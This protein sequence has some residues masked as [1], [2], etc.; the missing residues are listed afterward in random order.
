[1]L[2]KKSKQNKSLRKGYEKY[3]KKRLI[4]KCKDKTLHAMLKDFDPALYKMK[5]RKNP[6]SWSRN[7]KVTEV[8]FNLSHESSDDESSDESTFDV[9]S[10]RSRSSSPPRSALGTGPPPP[11]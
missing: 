7:E 6:S 10:S 1:M 8:A 3:L 5:A 9:A 4:K 11:S 2:R